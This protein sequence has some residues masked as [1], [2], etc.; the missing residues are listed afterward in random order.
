MELKILSYNVQCRG[1]PDPNKRRAAEI[2]RRVVPRRYD[3]VCFQEV[4]AE[5]ARKQFTSAFRETLPQMVAASGGQG[6]RTDSGLFVA[7]RHVGVAH[8]FEPFPWG[9]VIALDC[10]AQ[11]GVVAVSLDL[12]NGPDAFELLLLNTHFDA[13]SSNKRTYQLLVVRQLI[14]KTLS[15]SSDPAHV[16]VVLC[17]DLNIAAGSPEYEEMCKA[18]SVR[19][20]VAA[21]RKPGT[22]ELTHPARR[23]AQRLD[24]IVVFDRVKL[25]TTEV[26]LRRVDILDWAIDPIEAG[27]TQSDHLCLEATLS[28]R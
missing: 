14:E 23:P 3:A 24:Y 8:A 5:S 28:L 6:P 20:V 2:A 15:L 11:K 7:G 25:A 26:E 9:S 27:D 18:W 22:S 4:F 16:A 21:H 12:E 17:G 19:D 1:L 10:V 13:G